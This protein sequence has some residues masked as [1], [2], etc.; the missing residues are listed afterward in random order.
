VTALPDDSD[1]D[2]R[3]DPDEGWDDEWNR[4]DWYELGVADRDYRNEESWADWLI[5]LGVVAIVLPLLLGL[6]AYALILIF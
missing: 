3:Y 2:D 4:D 5:K 6:L 1:R